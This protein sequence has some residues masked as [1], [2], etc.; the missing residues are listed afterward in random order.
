MHY[1]NK[2]LLIDI[3]YPI[4]EVLYGCGLRLTECI[5]LRI[6]DVDYKLNEIIVRNGK[7]NNVHRTVFADKLKEPL[8]LQISKAEIAEQ[9]NVEMFCIGTELTR[10]T[11]EKPV[12][13]K[14][15]IQEVRSI[16]SGKITYAANWYNEIEEITFWNELNFVGIQAYFPLVKNKYPTVKQISRGWIKYFPA[17]ESIH[18]KYNRKILFTEMGYKSTAD[19]AIEPWKWV[20]DST[21]KD[22]HFS[23]ETQA[24]CY[25]AFFNTVWKKEWFAGVHIWQLRSDYIDHVG[26]KNLGFTP[27]GKPAENIIAKGFE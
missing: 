9:T 22:N 14:N 23:T 11:T 17:I 24:N 18:K 2:K 16:Y 19:S 4:F 15:L 20:E 27:Q 26:K 7:G 21:I 13:W 25:E 10:L 1:Y 8:K 3:E 12:Y 5:H 6:K